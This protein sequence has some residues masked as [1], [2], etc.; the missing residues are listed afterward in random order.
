M[1]AVNATE[2]AEC[3][4]KA[5]ETAM[6]FYDWLS[7]ELGKASLVGRPDDCNYCPV[8]VFVK[9]FLM[10]RGY[11]LPFVSVTSDVINVR[12]GDVVCEV[13]TPPWVARF[14]KALVE[15]CKR[16]HR[17]WATPRTAMDVL[18]RSLL[19]CDFAAKE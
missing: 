5:T 6:A 15:Q 17:E 10:Q 2:L 8:A 3:V 12:V 1:T 19:R 18:E 7:Q 16:D 13:P 14:E 9:E 11:H 4:R